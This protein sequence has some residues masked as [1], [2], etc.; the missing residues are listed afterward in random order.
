MV[1]YFVFSLISVLMDPE[2]DVPTAV[3]RSTSSPLAFSSSI[4]RASFFLYFS[5]SDMV[6]LNC[7]FSIALRLSLTMKA[8]RLSPKSTSW[9]FSYR[10]SSRSH[11]AHTIVRT[12]AHTILIIVR[13]FIG[14]VSVFSVFP[15]AH[16]MRY[17]PMS[18]ASRQSIACTVD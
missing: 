5:S 1:S 9:F 10:L 16:R 12:S 7:C 2:V 4:I 14:A 15:H 8:L 3:Y 6:S 17:V 11:F 18:S 13:L